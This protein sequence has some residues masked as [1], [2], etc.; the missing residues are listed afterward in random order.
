[1]YNLYPDWNPTDLRQ[2][3]GRIWRQKNEYGFVRVVMPL[4]QDSM[5]VFV[6]QKLEEKTYRIN[7]IWYR[8]DRGN[9]LDLESLDPEEVK[10]ALLTDIEAIAVSIIKKELKIQQRKIT[11][12]EENINTL[13][14]FVGWQQSYT[15]YKERA[16]AS[17]QYFCKILS[18]I[19]HV[20]NKPDDKALK[21]M[22]K[23]QRDK[24]KS[25]IEF[26]D[27]ATRFLEKTPVEDKEMLAI[28]RRFSNAFPY[29]E[30]YYINA[31]KE[32][33]SVLAKAEKTVWASKGFTAND[34]IDDVITAY[35]KDLEQAREQLANLESDRHKRDVIDE[36]RERKEQ[37]AVAGKSIEQ[38]VDEFASLNYLLSYKF[39][40]RPADGSIPKNEKSVVSEAK[41][42]PQPPSQP[43]PDAATA[44]RIRIAKAKMKL[45]NLDF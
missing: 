28:A 41:L 35:Q 44:L 20:K 42:L 22:E 31:F 40:D 10:Y 33:L 17:I 38:R 25:D 23:E 16:F 15:R 43:S 29:F 30:T 5:D 11:A 14:E 45:L 12:I 2:L 26:F 19:P 3:E 9:V 21:A 1:M 39:A 6:F 24:V 37:M 7:D 8:G 13:R 34:N 36:V 27:A 4:V 18:D 32:A